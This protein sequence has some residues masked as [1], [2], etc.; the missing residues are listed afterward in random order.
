MANS[1]TYKITN[2]SELFSFDFSQVLQTN[3]NI[4]SATCVVILMN[5]IDPTPQAILSGSTV[6]STPKVSQ[7]VI[8]GLNEVTYRL[9]MTAVTNQGNTYTAVGDITVYD[10]SQV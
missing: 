5:G 4:I 6:I 3:E 2:E 9:E 10:A 1:F 8:A 7:R